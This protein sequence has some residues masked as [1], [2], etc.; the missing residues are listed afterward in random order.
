[1]YT[2]VLLQ[3]SQGVVSLAFPNSNLTLK[4]TIMPK[5]LPVFEVMKLLYYTIG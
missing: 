2:H 5:S 4:Y 3:G 1:M